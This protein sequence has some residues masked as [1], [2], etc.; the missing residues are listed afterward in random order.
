MRNYLNYLS[1]VILSCCW[2]I[3]QRLCKFLRKCI[4]IRIHKRRV[5][6]FRQF[7]PYWTAVTWAD[8]DVES[9]LL[10]FAYPLKRTRHASAKYLQR[11]NPDLFADLD[12]NWCK[13]VPWQPGTVLGFARNSFVGWM[14]TV[15]IIRQL[16]R[17]I[18]QKF[19]GIGGEAELHAEISSHRIHQSDCI[20]IL[21]FDNEVVLYVVIN[22]MK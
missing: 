3:H 7:R 18:D 12:F 16:A 21:N 5:K 4:I 14:A 8:F 20:A 6:L 1:D 9:T 13:D 15:N 10:K 2:D 11:P 19:S 22:L 17:K